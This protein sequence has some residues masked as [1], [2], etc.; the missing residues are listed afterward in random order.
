[1]NL[2]ALYNLNL[3]SSSLALVAQSIEVGTDWCVAYDYTHAATYVS[4]RLA[5]DAE[6]SA[7]LGCYLFNACVVRMLGL[8][9]AEDNSTCTDFLL[10]DL[11]DWESE[12]CTAVKLKLAEVLC[13]G[14]C[15]HTCIVWTW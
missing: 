7:C 12:D 13:A 11:W 9:L 15:Y 3:G 4:N 6:I 2:L 14:K 5:E 8:N 1:M 10:S